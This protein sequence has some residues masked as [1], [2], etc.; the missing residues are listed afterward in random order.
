MKIEK[1]LCGEEVYL[2]TIYLSPT[3][4][5]ENT[6]KKFQSLGEEITLFQRKGKM[7]LQGDLNARTG[8][9]EDII[10]LDKFDQD[11]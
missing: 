9:K 7:I 5:K 4:N 2:G 11:I 1:E 8:N 6:V 3:G 10:Q